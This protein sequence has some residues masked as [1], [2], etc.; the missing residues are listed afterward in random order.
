MLQVG[1]AY[2]FGATADVVSPSGNTSN[3]CELHNS[4]GFYIAMVGAVSTA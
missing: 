4:G 1:A 2:D 3:C